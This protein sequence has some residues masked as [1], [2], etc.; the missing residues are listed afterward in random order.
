[1]IDTK[2]YDL[3]AN[4]FY[5]TL[6]LTSLPINSWDLYA[7]YFDSICQTVSDVHALKKLAKGNNWSYT[8][9]FNEELLEKE[10]I[11]VVTDPQLRIVH[12]TKN[13]LKMNGYKPK[14]I[15]GKK[16]KMFQGAET[17]KNTSKKIGLAI[18]KALPF[19]AV[20]LNYRKDGSKYKCWIKGEPILNKSGE[21]VNFIAYEKEVA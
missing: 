4:K 14:E 11:I 17:C 6:N 18:K 3:A 1:M 9:N 12:A 21:V 16:P 5:S 19:E 15:L 7:T 8:K 13:I 20:I 2:N 10:H